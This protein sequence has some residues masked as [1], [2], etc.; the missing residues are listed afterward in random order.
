MVFPREKIHTFEI[1]RFLLAFWVL[2]FHFHLL[3]P[4][5]DLRES[6]IQHEFWNNF[7]SMGYIA[8]P[9]FWMLSGTI[10]T[11]RYQNEFKFKIYVVS[12]IARLLPLH[13]VTLVLVAYIQFRL[14]PDVIYTCCNDTKHFAIQFFALHGLGLEKGY[15]FNGPSWSIS[16]ELLALM[17][18]G[19]YCR[20]RQISAVASFS[21]FLLFATITLAGAAI[22][23]HF[24]IDPHRFTRGFA[25][26]TYFFLGSLLYFVVTRKLLTISLLILV[27][28]TF[29]LIVFSQFPLFRSILMIN[30]FV[31]LPY[32]TLGFCVI[33]WLA[34][35]SG[36][37]SKLFG[38]HIINLSTKLGGYA[39]NLY[40]LHIPVQL[41]MVWFSNETQYRWSY[42]QLWFA[43]IFVCTFLSILSHH[44][45]EEPIR[46]LIL[47][48]FS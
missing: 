47:R 32:I 18:F 14:N 10:L 15:T 2:A 30:S 40:L 1:F 26:C 34:F 41:L 6:K 37:E 19:L 42:G 29:L 35:R 36:S 5:I 11:Y 24:Q 25:A 21:L 48:L 45:F 31:Y 27:P 28:S 12:R 22:A 9:I 38:K 20:K 33:C 13:F 17:L 8:V 46:K 39:F 7:L 23:F 4:N 43:Y 44:L 3:L 16:S